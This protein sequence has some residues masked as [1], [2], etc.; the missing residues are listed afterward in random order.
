[1]R[2]ARTCNVF[3][4]C[5]LVP[6]HDLQW[7][8]HCQVHHLGF[9]ET[10]EGAARCY[11]AAVLELRGPSAPTNFAIIA[12]GDSG[13]HADVLRNVAAASLPK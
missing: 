11:D 5:N 2:V 3:H 12:A 1:M 7:L 9:F 10:E 13:L 8:P 6:R 4:Q